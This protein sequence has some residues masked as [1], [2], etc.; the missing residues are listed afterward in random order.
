[1]P[2]PTRKRLHSGTPNFLNLLHS[3]IIKRGCFVHLYLTCF[4][5]GNSSVSPVGNKNMADA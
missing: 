1:M 4:L 5:K 2:P 3:H